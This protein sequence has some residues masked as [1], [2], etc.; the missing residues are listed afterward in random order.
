MNRRS[1]KP[2]FLVLGFLA[3]LLAANLGILLGWVLPW[4][5]NQP[6]SPPDAAANP[7]V[8]A[9][10]PLPSLSATLPR[11]TNASLNPPG[12]ATAALPPA[13]A[14]S[15]LR[16]Q[17]VIIL[18]M[19]DGVNHHL[20]AYHPQY[21]PFTRLT[22]GAWDDIDPAISPDGSQVA[23]AS[24]QNGYYDLFVLDL[25]TGRQSRLTDTPAYDGAPTWS[26]DG[27]FIAYE[28]YT[29][30]GTQLFIQ[31]VTDLKEPPVQLT[32]APGQ[33]FTPA[34][35]PGGREIAFVSTRSG[36]E[37]VWLARLD[38]IDDR[39][40]D[41]SLSGT[42]RDRAPRWSP[43][44]SKLAWATDTPG[45]DVLMLWDMKS[46]NSLARQVGNGDTPVWSPQGDALL[47]E[48]REPN[49]T[50]LAVYHVPDGDYIFPPNHIPGHLAGLDW[51]AGPVPDHIASFP[52]PLNAQKP[53][54]ALYQP[55][56]TVQA[57]LQKNRF[58]LV[59][60]KDVAAP[61][62]FLQ[63]STDE[64]FHALRQAVS[65]AVGWDFL[66]TLDNAYLPIT[67][68]SLPG[69]QDNWLYTG[70]AFDVI[71]APL[72]AGWMALIRED[73]GGQ[74]YWRVYVRCLSQDASMGAPLNQRPWDL[75]A[76]YRGDPRTYDLGGDYGDIPDG[77]WVDFT[78]LAV[79]YGWER[80]PAM[81][82]WR[83]YYQGAEF[84]TFVMREGLTWDA[85]MDQIYPNE[86]VS[87]PTPWYTLTPT[88][89]PTPTLY[90]Q[91]LITPSITPTPTLTATLHPT[92]TLPRAP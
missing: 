83:T 51:K 91:R 86:A 17:G 39:F 8:S 41:I 31:K 40:V 37:D 58:A 6:S 57:G 47:A 22:N 79:R 84:N 65:R 19:S 30:A 52:V 64:S 24:R 92:L 45:T 50:S 88:I 66:G 63:D 14:L 35:S 49:L 74:T 67:T 9:K 59:P 68:V 15:G 5:Q 61:Y 36:Q 69:M 7:A 48:I 43:D 16:Q 4:M 10:T 89:T 46:P 29:A 12:G 33:S 26:P 32:A 38:R 3:I 87:T 42:G 62:P 70:R 80:L 72:T 82:N 25:A 2:I 55:A 28:S 77:Y 81:I 85:A 20:F 78:A 90:Y 53:A 60:I 71:P 44:G 73:I 27:Q 76:R 23:F 34:W 13:N 18:S 1:A 11:A 56:L 54:A 75:S 21:L